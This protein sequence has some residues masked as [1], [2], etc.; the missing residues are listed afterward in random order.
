[1]RH[2]YRGYRRGV[3]HR[4]TAYR[5]ILEFLGWVVLG[6]AI[7]WILCVAVAWSFDKSVENRCNYWNMNLTLTEQMEKICLE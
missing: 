2:Y 4:F 7:M 5:Y 6:A 3:S 1:M